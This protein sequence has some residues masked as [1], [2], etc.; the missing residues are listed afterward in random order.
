VQVLGDEPAGETGGAEDDEVEFLPV[1]HAALPFIASQ[2]LR[3]S[4]S[5]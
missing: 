3:S 4:A 5:E 2:S 1:A